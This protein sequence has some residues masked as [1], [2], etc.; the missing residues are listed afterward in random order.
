MFE[1]SFKNIDNILQSLKIQK[2]IIKKLDELSNQT[3]KTG[4][5][6]PAKI[7]GFGGVEK[8]SAEESF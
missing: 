5:D 7:G 6:L 8:I 1:Q 4:N 3:K 2:Q